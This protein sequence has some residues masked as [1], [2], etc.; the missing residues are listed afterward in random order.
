MFETGEVRAAFVAELE[1]MLRAWGAK[2]EV[3]RDSETEAPHMVACIDAQYDGSGRK[4]R[5][6]TVVDLGASVG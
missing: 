6:Y 3:E 1:T 4:E 5:E 2:L